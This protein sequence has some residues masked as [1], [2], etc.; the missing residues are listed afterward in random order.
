VVYIDDVRKSPKG[1][2]QG[3]YAQFD[4]PTV[5]IN[6]SGYKVTGRRTQLQEPKLRF[7]VHHMDLTGEDREKMKLNPKH[8]PNPIVSDLRSNEFHLPLG[9]RVVYGSSHARLPA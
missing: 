4:K 7:R 5:S 2:S 8:V 6:S 3:T 9:L 1:T